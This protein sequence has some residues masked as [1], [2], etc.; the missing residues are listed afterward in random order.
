MSVWTKAQHV[1][2]DR[3]QVLYNTWLIRQANKEKRLQWARA[4]LD[5]EDQPWR[6]FLP[7]NRNSGRS[8]DRSSDHSNR[9]N[10]ASTLTRVAFHK[11]DI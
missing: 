4:C 2:Q 6:H 8:S 9:R 11:N 5:N 3:P 1:S 10:D 7:R